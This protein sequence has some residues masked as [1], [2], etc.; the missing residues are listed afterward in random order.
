[1]T[2]PWLKNALKHSLVL[3]SFIIIALLYFSPVL[4]GKEIYQSDIVWSKGM[5]KKQLDYRAANPGKE[6]YWTDSAFSGMPTYQLGARYPHDYIKKLDSVL[7]FLPRPADYLMLYF[8]GFYLL[9]LV[10]KIDYRLAALG[11]LAF[12]FSTYLIVIIEAG[13]NAKAHAIGYMPLVLAGI[14]LT[15]KRKYVWGFLLTAVAMALEV[16]AN[17]YQM[18]YY[19]M[20]LVLVLG[21][22]FLIEAWKKKE[23]PA[24]F[25]TVGI[26]SAAVLLALAINATPLLATKEYADTSTRSKSELTINVDGSEKIASSGLDKDYILEYNYGIFESLNLFISRLTGGG[27]VENLGTDSNIYSFLLKQG[28]SPMQARQ[29]AEQV[30]TY[31]GEQPGT[32]GPAYVGAVILFLFVLSLFLVK[33]KIKWWLVGGTVLSLLLSYGKNLAVLSYFFID[34]FPLYN[35][36]RA[37]T[38]IQVILELCIPLLAIIGLAKM[39]SSEI[40]KEAKL[41]ALKFATAITA[42]I[43]VII[44][45]VKGTLDFSATNDAVYIQNYGR[46]FINAVIADRKDLLTQDTI[47]TL[48][49]V[50]LSGLTILLLVHN[51]IKQNIAILVFAALILFDLVGVDRR[52]VNDDNFVAGRQVA[53]PFVAT[54]ADTQ[55]LADKSHY[56]VLD[57]KDGASRAAY[58]HNSVWGYHAAKPGRYQELFDFHI[59][60]QNEEVFNML[61]IKYI[62]A[63][64]EEVMQNEAAYG[65]AW[66]VSKVLT[67]PDANTEIRMLDSLDLS[68]TAVIGQG[69][70]TSESK[71]STDSLATIQLS[72]YKPDHLVYR[73]KTK[74]KS[75]AVFSETYYAKGWNAYINGELTPHIRVNYVLRALEIPAG[76]HTVEFKFEPAVVKTGSTIALLGSSI[77]VLLLIA[78]LFIEWKSFKTIPK[79]E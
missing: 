64:E 27:S 77:F 53:K 2:T 69:F 35:K 25:K 21:I 57:A 71:F 32:A 74:V 14:L 1:M 51:K 5:S 10:L 54:K 24:F 43:A 22:S 65:N 39:F 18:T 6:L 59:S 44:L 47:R 63:S 73:A 4:Q 9:L 48:T 30:P 3:V 12:G 16:Y 17:H 8:L 42:G 15:F 67:V 58:F 28:V 66:F 46:D 38:S 78:A 29:F 61:N 76:E 33:G 75:L 50:L 55:I 40:S 20:L 52:Y 26:L 79:I 72:S 7:R 60:K 11:A 70:K 13:H 23:L 31:W 56:R 49:L 34:Y 19:L 36:F 41:K 37:V 62:I 68:N 45:L